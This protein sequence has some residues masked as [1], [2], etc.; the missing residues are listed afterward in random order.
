MSQS[1]TT[2]TANWQ[3]RLNVTTL[4]SIAAPYDYGVAFGDSA[5]LLYAQAGRG[6]SNA[7]ATGILSYNTNGKNSTGNLN[8]PLAV[9][10]HHS[11]RMSMTANMDSNNIAWYFGGRSEKADGSMT[12]YNDIYTYDSNNSFWGEVVDSVQ[13]SLRPGYK[14]GHTANLVK[15]KLFV[16]GGIAATLNTTSNTFS[17]IVQDFSTSLVFNLSTT[18]CRI[19]NVST[20]KDIP[21]SRLEHSMAEG[22]DGHSL[23]LFGGWYQAGEERTFYNDVWVL[24][25]CTM[26][27]AQQTVSGTAPIG[28]GGHEAVRVGNYMIIMG[29]MSDITN[30]ICISPLGSKACLIALYFQ[31][32][33]N[34]TSETKF[35]YTNELAILDMSSWT[36]VSQFTATPTQTIAPV[37]TCEFA[38]PSTNVGTGG[39]PILPLDPI[40]YNNSGSSE[41]KKLGFGISFSTVAF[42]AI[43]GA[44]IWYFYRR[45]KRTKASTPYWL[46]GMGNDNSNTGHE[47]GVYPPANH[48]RT[49]DYP[50]FVYDPEGE[51]NKKKG[52]IALHEGEPD[53]R[54]YTASD[55]HDW[56][57]KEE[58]IRPS[59]G[60]PLPKHSSLWNRVRGLG[61]SS[62]DHD[63]QAGL[64]KGADKQGWTRLEDYDED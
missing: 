60:R 52:E 13:Q 5:G 27:W 62:T 18:D 12:Y 23:V 28:R 56:R 40:V 24:D 42:L 16:L 17:E 22:P 41:A 59:D 64:I 32:Y 37:L 53:S 54:T 25:T 14:A 48:S 21:P 8:Q 38:F 51:K 55:Q 2:T 57:A 58:E 33:T 11:D 63:D 30:T 9:G 45:R 31:G 50:M 6:G 19:A 4:S 39:T 29:G 61:D 49:T 3:S 36:W 1:F 47:L 20:G 26:D 10:V 7:L 46:P 15:G 35:T 44:G 43:V 34:F